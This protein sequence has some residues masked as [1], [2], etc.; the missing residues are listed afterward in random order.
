MNE[1]EQRP[2]DDPSGSEPRTNPY[3]QPLP[4]S[5]QQSSDEHSAGDSS[6]SERGGSTAYP[7]PSYGQPSQDPGQA[8]PYGQ[9]PPPY[10]QAPS[11]HGQAPQPYGQAPQPYGQAPQYGQTSSDHG[12]APQPYGQAPQQSAYGSSPYDASY[13][14]RG[15][16]RPGTVTA[17]GWITI[18]LGVLGTLGYLALAAAFF[19]GKDFM[20]ET[21]QED[22]Q[23]DEIASAGFT[24]DAFV[25]LLGFLMLGVAIWSAANVVLG[26]L[27]LKRSNVA[28]ILLIVSC[29]LT[30]LLSLFAVIGGGIGVISLVPAVAVIVLLFV[31][32]AKEWFARQGQASYGGAYPGAPYGG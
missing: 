13:G 18:V 22:P 25:T 32:G 24:V 12:Q 1:N 5:A 3:G 2:S 4:P 15:D 8:P 9:A 21:F 23:F 16:A 31:G 29:A 14:T 30:A 7:P 20:V 17:A 10:G 11:E 19:L 26:I 6:G 28:R 27:V